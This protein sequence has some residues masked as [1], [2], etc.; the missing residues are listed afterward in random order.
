LRSAGGTRRALLARR[1]SSIGF[2]RYRS[3][4]LLERRYEIE[5][6]ESEISSRT[7]RWIVAVEGDRAVRDFLRAI[8]RQNLVFCHMLEEIA[9]AKHDDGVTD[10]EHTLPTV[11]ARDHFHGAA[12]AQDDVAPAL[13]ARRPVIE[14]AEQEAEI[15]LL[16]ME[17]SNA[18]AGATIENSE[19]L[20]AEP[21]VNDERIAVA[22]QSRR[23]DDEIGGGARPKVW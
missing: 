10:D 1:D 23:L 5:K 8:Y 14:L 2:R 15:R 6:I 9:E 4:G 18:E 17:L 21:L 22:W 12:K 20:F 7:E 19:P 13:A 11:F 16:G 3:A